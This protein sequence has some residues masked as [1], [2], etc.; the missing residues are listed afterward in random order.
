ML[1]ATNSFGAL[2]EYQYNLVVLGS[3]IGSENV[4]GTKFSIY[5]SL[6]LSASHNLNEY[7]LM[8]MYFKVCSRVHTQERA[9]Y[10]KTIYHTNLRTKFSLCIAFYPV[11]LFFPCTISEFWRSLSRTWDS[12][13]LN[14][15]YNPRC[16]R[17]TG[18]ARS[19]I[20]SMT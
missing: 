17:S 13:A 10:R 19:R 15:V 20:W 14:L 11:S 8:C 7:M 4:D 12:S 2:Y 18:H 5:K 3:Q 1:L 6:S 9:K 16:T